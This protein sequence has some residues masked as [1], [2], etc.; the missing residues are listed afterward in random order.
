LPD[1]VENQRK[2]LPIALSSVV[3]AVL[4]TNLS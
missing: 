1:C 2:I 4:I 3:Y